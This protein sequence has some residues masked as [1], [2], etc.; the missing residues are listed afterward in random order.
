MIR[1]YTIGNPNENKFVSIY[2]AN[3]VRYSFDADHLAHATFF[4][5]KVSVTQ[6]VDRLL[7]D[8]NLPDG[9]R[10]LTYDCIEVITP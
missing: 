10:L 7:R 8:G 6:T 5:N 4:Q 2:W 3:G 1:V 9:F